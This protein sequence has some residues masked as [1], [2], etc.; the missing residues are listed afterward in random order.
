MGPPWC[1]VSFDSN[2][3][4]E[5]EDES[6]SAHFPPV[7]RGDYR[8]AGDARSGEQWAPERAEIWDPRMNSE[9]GCCPQFLSPGRRTSL[10]G[11]CPSVAGKET[12]VLSGKHG[13]RATV[14]QN[15]AADETILGVLK[16]SFRVWGRVQ[17]VLQPLRLM[18]T[19]HED[20]KRNPEGTRMPRLGGPAGVET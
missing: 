3:L 12:E 16:K 19:Q 9:T 11:P 7:K 15:E 10:H 2:L 6:L 8:L 4:C 17:A 5:F 1:S 13:F 20:Q 18:R 14:F